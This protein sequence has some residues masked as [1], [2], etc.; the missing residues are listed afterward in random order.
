[1]GTKRTFGALLAKWGL[2][3]LHLKTWFLEAEVEFNDASRRAAWDLYVELLTRITTQPLAP[4]DGIEARAL[5]SVYELFGLTRTALKTHG[6]D[7]YAFARVAVVI[8]N[9][10]VRPFTAKWH[11]LSV[12]GAFED[13]DD[14][15][16]F[17]AELAELQV[18]LRHYMQLLA[19][20]IGIEDDLVDPDGITLEA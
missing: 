1:M 16:V 4:A 9:Q 19:D 14:C 15:G 13:V 18:D 7:C 2:K 10:V 11:K 20:L 3:K 17:R 5:T 8:L 12:E 6:P